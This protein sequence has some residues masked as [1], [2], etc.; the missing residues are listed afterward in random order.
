MDK[1]TGAAAKA[2]L[3]AALFG[4]SAPVS[5]ILLQE[6]P[7]TLLAGLL[8]LGAGAGMAAVGFFGNAGHKGDK[9]EK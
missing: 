5:K 9:E 4:I 3:A 8:Y 6:I 2:V 1:S 7:E